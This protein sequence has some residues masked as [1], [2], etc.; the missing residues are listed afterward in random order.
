METIKG[1][2]EEI[3]SDIKIYFDENE[4]IID[5]ISP[6]DAEE[7]K[8]KGCVWVILTNL[9][10]IFHTQQIDKEPLVALIGR[11]DI[12]EVEYFEREKDILLTF[13]PSNNPQNVTK[14]TFKSNKKDELE[15]FCED[16]GDF[17][18]Y[19]RE[20]DKGIEV[21]C[22]AI[23]QSKRKSAISKEK[24]SLVERLA[25]LK[26]QN[27]LIKK[28][29]EKSNKRVQPTLEIT[30]EAEKRSQETDEKP[31]SAV[32]A[33]K[34]ELPSLS[35]IIKKDKTAPIKSTT[36]DK[37]KE[38]LSQDKL[39]LKTAMPKAKEEARDSA[40]KIEEPVLKQSSTQS[41][42]K[43]KVDLDTLFKK[44]PKVAPEN[45]KAQPVEAKLEFETIEN[46]KEVEKKDKALATPME[47][48]T[49]KDKQESE[50]EL[51]SITSAISSRA[52]KTNLD[53]QK[54][55]LVSKEKYKVGKGQTPP[56]RKSIV[57]AFN[58][59]AVSK[60]IFDDEAIEQGVAGSKKFNDITL[61]N[62][63]YKPIS[64]VIIT[65]ISLVVAYIWYKFFKLVSKYE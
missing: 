17:I 12:R 47:T 40:T 18:T 20:T 63:D 6:F 9:S 54:D 30:T 59:E 28:G 16:I 24:D 13:V 38:P 57:K 19:K 29:I 45:L 53:Q 23:P 22:T 33:L 41:P 32:S 36:V 42:P 37:D 39:N 7:Q 8:V 3:I 27:D 43:V 26:Y 5:A 11:D 58:T 21:L 61:E 65:G 1:L 4:R 51:P 50:A 48:S 52:I 44:E 46:V 15:Q 64:I 25:L 34:H 56:L 10:V 31:E 35:E 55:T 14:L 62:L 60:E 2:S 49:N